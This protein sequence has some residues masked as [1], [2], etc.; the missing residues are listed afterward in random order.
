MRKLFI[1]L[2]L[3]PLA[4]QA[5]P[6]LC[7]DWTPANICNAET[8][9]VE[10]SFIDSLTTQGKFIHQIVESTT[11]NPP[12]QTYPESHAINNKEIWVDKLD[13]LDSREYYYCDQENAMNM[14]KLRLCVELCLYRVA[15]DWVSASVVRA[16]MAHARLVSRARA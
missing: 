1:L 13:T 4:V 14:R 11:I 2:L 15:D 10:Q 3:F 6:Y 7:G 5:A 9:E 16:F 8:G 12:T